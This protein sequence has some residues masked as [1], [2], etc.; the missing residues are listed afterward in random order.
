[1]VVG[2]L[3]RKH[4]KKSTPRNLELT[5]VEKRFGREIRDRRRNFPKPL[6]KFTP[7]IDSFSF[8]QKFFS[9]PN[10]DIM[11]FHHDLRAMRKCQRQKRFGYK[12]LRNAL[13]YAWHKAPSLDQFHLPAF[14]C[15]KL[16]DSE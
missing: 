13:L 4:A 5:F 2:N 8:D 3:D 10:L 14:T 11:L 6:I 15:S 12:T 9:V 16:T 7:F 1:M